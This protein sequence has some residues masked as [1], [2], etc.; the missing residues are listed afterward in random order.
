MGQSCADILE[1]DGLS[2]A[3]NMCVGLKYPYENLTLALDRSELSVSRPGSFISQE[4]SSATY[5]MRG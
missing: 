4:N 5:Y 2:C 3:M 1:N